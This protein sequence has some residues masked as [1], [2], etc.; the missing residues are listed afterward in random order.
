MGAGRKV[1]LK[2]GELNA[3]QSGQDWKCMWVM[4]ETQRIK[5]TKPK[6]SLDIFNDIYRFIS[7]FKCII[8]CEFFLTQKKIHF[9]PNSVFILSYYLFLEASFQM[10]RFSGF[11]KYGSAP[12]TLTKLPG[13]NRK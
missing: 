1:Q 10:V 2:S 9:I 12:W 7:F 11:I 3:S 8:C 6:T 4:K 5:C 13:T